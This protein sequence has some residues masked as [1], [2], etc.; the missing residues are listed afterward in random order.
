MSGFALYDESMTTWDTSAEP[1]ARPEYKLGEQRLNV[2]SLAQRTAREEKQIAI[3]GQFRWMEGGNLEPLDIDGFGYGGYREFS[4]LDVGNIIYKDNPAIMKTK[5]TLPTIVDINKA[6]GEEAQDLSEVKIPNI[7]RVPPWVVIDNNPVINL[8]DPEFEELQNYQLDEITEDQADKVI[9]GE[10]PNTVRVKLASKSVLDLPQFKYNRTFEPIRGSTRTAQEV[11]NNAFSDYGN[12]F[13]STT[14]MRKSQDQ[15]DE[16]RR[17]N[18]NHNFQKNI[19]NTTFAGKQEATGGTTIPF[20]KTKNLK[21]TA[22]KINRKM[23][24][25]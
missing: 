2:R 10:P 13:A 17:S 15:V 19:F 18:A 6:R 21:K 11:L 25:P 4:A 8:N 5:D 1:R 23:R 3:G 7:P 14:L 22:K 16:V 9:G 20:K 12:Q 24:R